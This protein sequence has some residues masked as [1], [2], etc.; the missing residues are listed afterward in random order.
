MSQKKSGHV[1]DNADKQNKEDSLIP[2]GE[3][4]WRK[5]EEDLLDT[6]VNLKQNNENETKPKEESTRQEKQTEPKN[7][8]EKATKKEQTSTKP[9]NKSQDKTKTTEKERKTD[10]KQKD[11]LTSEKESA[12]A[13][14]AKKEYSIEDTLG[15]IDFKE[16]SVELESEKK[17]KKETKSP[18]QSTFVFKKEKKDKAKRKLITREKVKTPKIQLPK[19]KFA[20]RVLWLPISLVVALFIGLIVGNTVIGEQPVSE[21]FNIENW[22][23][24]YKLIFTK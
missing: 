20:L 19:W 1:A 8:K 10:Q 22:F 23:H 3:L 5:E 15:P 14:E 11:K 12:A 4:K 2:N 17:K 24:L 13:S 7:S 18:D 16:Y 6:D 21:A 9:Q